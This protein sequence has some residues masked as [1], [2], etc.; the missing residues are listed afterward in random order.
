MA[1]LAQENDYRDKSD[2]H[3]Y[4]EVKVFENEIEVINALFPDVS[5]VITKSLT[6]LRDE[7]PARHDM[8]LVIKAAHYEKA[9]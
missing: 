5:R 8:K 2:A 7:G 6:I 3:W 1:S 4:E 9:F